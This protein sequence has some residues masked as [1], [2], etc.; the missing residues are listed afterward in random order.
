MNR[1]KREEEV[2]ILVDLPEEL[3]RE[4]ERRAQAENLKVEELLER[5]I[6]ESLSPPLIKRIKYH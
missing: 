6:K 3:V 5:F 2:Q 4:L 1:R